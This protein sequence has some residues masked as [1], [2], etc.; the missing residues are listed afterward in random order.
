MKKLTLSVISLFLIFNSQAVEA[1]TGTVQRPG[2][3]LLQL[4]MTDEVDQK[5]ERIRKKLIKDGYSHQL[6]NDLFGEENFY[7][8]TSVEK[9]YTVLYVVDLVIANE[10][11][12]E[13]DKLILISLVEKAYVLY[14]KEEEANN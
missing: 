11:Y 12:K 9:Y 13:S 5:V 10:Q 4:E 7:F 1:G 14:T 2:T 3:L 6:M 8:P